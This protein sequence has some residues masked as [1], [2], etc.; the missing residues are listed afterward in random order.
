MMTP[1]MFPIRRSYVIFLT[2]TY[3]CQSWHKLSPTNLVTIAAINLL[4]SHTS[5]PS[6]AQPSPGTEPS[7]IFYKAAVPRRP[8]WTLLGGFGER[9]SSTTHSVCIGLKWHKKEIN[10]WPYVILGTYVDGGLLVAS[11]FSVWRCTSSHD[12]YSHAILSRSVRLNG[13]IYYTPC[14]FEI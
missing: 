8:F 5:Q 3:I 6:P 2:I 14:P 9:C 13:F 1:A 10:R 11:F 7:T 12:E 4:P